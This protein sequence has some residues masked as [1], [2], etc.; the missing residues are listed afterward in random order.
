MN[1]HLILDGSNLLHRNYWVSKIR[2]NQVPVGLLFLNSI[3][4]LSVQYPGRKCLCVWDSRQIRGVKNFRQLSKT[5]YKQN[6]DKEK[7]ADVFSHEAHVVDMSTKL[8][9]YHLNPGKLEADDFIHWL[10]KQSDDSVVVSSDSDLLQLVSNKCSVYNPIKDIM[11]T[12][13]NFYETTK[14]GN[15]N[16]LIE[17]KC[18]VG[19][20]S[21]NIPGLVGYGIKRATKLLESNFEGLTHEQKKQLKMNRELIDLKYGLIKHPEE[22]EVYE[23][24]YERVLSK[25]AKDLDSFF[26]QCKRHKYNSILN[27]QSEWRSLFDSTHNISN[28]ATNLIRLLK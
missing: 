5:E 6:R 26:K 18:I 13:E 20:K 23:Q 19:D 28:L 17:L 22:L 11:Y 12:E 10:T 1:K 7:N 21:D 16:W 8:G 4:K 27:K 3:K 24:T 25:D 15:V 2:K 9:V 14:C